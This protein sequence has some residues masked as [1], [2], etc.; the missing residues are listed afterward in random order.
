M[1]SN[2]HGN[3]RENSEGKSVNK[4]LADGDGDG[5]GQVFRAQQQDG[6]HAMRLD[7]SHGNVQRIDAFLYPLLIG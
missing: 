5:V 6:L 4:A 1:R 7:G 3:C 2:G